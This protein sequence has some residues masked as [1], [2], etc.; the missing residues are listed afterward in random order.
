MSEKIAALVVTYN[1]AA[2]LVEC[3]EAL[4]AQTRPVDKIIIVENAS[5]DGTFEAMRANGYL[6][7]P[8]IDYERLPENLGGSAA[9]NRC[10]EK[11]ID[12]GYDWLWMMDDDAEPTLSALETLCA[13]RA[14]PQPDTSAVA[15]K[16]VDVT[17]RV[18]ERHC[19]HFHKLGC[20]T[21][22]PASEY[23]KAEV[24]IGY[25]SFVGLA[26]SRKAILKA[27]MPRRDFF[28]WYDDLEYC[29]RLSRVG[30]IYLVSNSIMKH[31]DDYS[32][33]QQFRWLFWKPVKPP[34][35]TYWKH[36]CGFRNREYV[37]RKYGSG[38]ALLS[39]L[40]LFKRL[41]RILLFEDRKILKVKWTILYYLDSYRRSFRTLTPAQWRSLCKE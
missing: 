17:G 5:T 12:A 30:N 22:L 20:Q 21:P 14:M 10:F 3:I 23:D 8:L 9:W 16:K 31:K 27:G 11:A 28:M 7:N 1:R 13:S 25:S 35:V 36:L 26:I 38:G 33:I 37:L 32:E 29:L 34:T 41:A 15:C 18:E 19:G 40:R 39:L 6:D 4:L 2:L 24:R